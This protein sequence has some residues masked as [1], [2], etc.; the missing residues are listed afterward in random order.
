LI[1]FLPEFLNFL[2]ENRDIIILLDEEDFDRLV[3]LLVFYK[4][5]FS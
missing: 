1:K 3:D 5:N 4:M 2:E